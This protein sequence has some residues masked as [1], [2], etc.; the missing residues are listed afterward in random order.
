MRACP[1]RLKRGGEKEGEDELSGLTH[2]CRV[3]LESKV[4]SVNI[5]IKGAVG[6]N[7]EPVSRLTHV[8]HQRSRSEVL[9]LRPKQELEADIS[10]H[11]WFIIL[12]TSLYST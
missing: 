7:H 2:I 1:A 11:A 3:S 10:S 6:Y 5:E 8:P 9:C 4:T 12:Y